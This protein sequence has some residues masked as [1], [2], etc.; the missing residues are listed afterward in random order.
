MKQGL[1]IGK[2]IDITQKQWLIANAMFAKIPLTIF[3][4]GHYDA[5]IKKVIIAITS[6]KS[7]K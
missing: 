7:I 4:K 3:P 5:G 2:T 1:K 6:L